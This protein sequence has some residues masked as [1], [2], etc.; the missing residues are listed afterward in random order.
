MTSTKSGRNRGVMLDAVYRA[1]SLEFGADLDDATYEHLLRV[2]D[3]LFHRAALDDAC[4]LRRQAASNEARGV[5]RLVGQLRCAGVDDDP[6]RLLEKSASALTGESRATI[7]SVLRLLAKTDLPELGIRADAGRSAAESAAMNWL[8]RE[9]DAKVTARDVET[10]LRQSRRFSGRVLSVRQLSGGFSKTTLLIE[11]D[12]PINGENGH[13]ELV[14][15]QVTPGR[16]SHTL[17]PEFDVLRYAF[18]HDVAV[19]EPLWIEPEANPLGGPFFASSRA[20]GENPGDVFG[21][22]EGV[23]KGAG[24]ALA[25]SLGQLHGVPINGAPKTP[26]EP[27]VRKSDLLDAIEQQSV[28][29][30]NSPTQSDVD[31][32]PLHALLFEWLRANAPGDVA[33]PVLLHGDPGFHNMLVDGHT[34]TAMLDWERSRIGDAA[35]DLAYVKPYV[36]DVIPWN[37]FMDAYCAAGGKRPSEDVMHFY[38]VWQ[39]AWRFAGAHR[40]R[41]RLISGGRG[42]L[43]GVLALLHAPRFLIGALE[44]AY[45]VTL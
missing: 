41:A 31:G 8:G 23:D 28:S 30:G 25:A 37:E 21:A 13:R 39:D 7:E 16:D 24:L 33:E 18:E 15:R 22:R 9:A 5:G 10:Y 1:M 27:M 44:S 32:Q 2:S 12:S 38:T 42:L 40:G 4:G 43:D 26:V 36:R 17:S 29:V 11:L 6:Y 34:L 20:P 3:V 45:G 14:V 35:Q 19:A